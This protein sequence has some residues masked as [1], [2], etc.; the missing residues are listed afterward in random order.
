MLQEEKQIS[1]RYTTCNSNVN[2][3]RKAEQRIYINQRLNQVK[4][5]NQHKYEN[6]AVLND[7]QNVA[8]SEF[9]FLPRTIHVQNDHV[10][11]FLL[12]QLPY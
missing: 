11:S 4:R 5:I 9:S 1:N 12:L 10:A 8:L 3:G 6:T 2:S 7:L